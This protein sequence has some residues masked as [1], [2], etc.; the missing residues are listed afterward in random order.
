MSG[1]L[2]VSLHTFFSLFIIFVGEIYLWKSNLILRGKSFFCKT[3]FFVRE[4]F[5]LQDKSF[6]EEKFFLQKIRREE[7]KGH[8]ILREKYIFL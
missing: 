8:L 4:K 3:N 5:F 6:S 7:Y 2:Q 1:L